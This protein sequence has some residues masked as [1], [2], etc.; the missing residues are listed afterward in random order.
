MRCTRMLMP[1]MGGL[2]EARMRMRADG[3]KVC[4]VAVES[5]QRSS[6]VSAAKMCGPEPQR[7][8]ARG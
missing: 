3:K 8:G 5:G 6:D 4:I 2:L 7:V 1:S